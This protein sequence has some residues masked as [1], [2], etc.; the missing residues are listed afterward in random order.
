MAIVTEQRVPPLAAG[1][2]LTRDEFL[3]RW[4]AQPEVKRAE[5]IAGRVY[6]P[7]PVSGD[8]GQMDRWISGW[9]AVYQAATPGVDGANN[10]TSLMLEDA[11]Q[12][13]LSLLILPE[14]GGN[15]SRDGL[16]YQGALEFV[17]EVS[18]TSASN[19]LHDKYDLY[20]S[21]GVQEYLVI[22]LFEEEIRWHELVDGRYRVFPPDADGLWRSRVFPGL[23]LDGKALLAGNL[24]QVL[25][26]LQDGLRSAEH[27]R[28][29]ADLAARRRV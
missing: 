20:Q 25:D 4:E 21:A 22:L 29:V 27:D 5:L 18:A 24:R 3:R 8:H 15:S 16:Y 28:F 10:A 11:P 2:H 12:P 9:L 7:S 26:R 17:A 14:Y 13:D 19:D 1:D 6:M 23:W